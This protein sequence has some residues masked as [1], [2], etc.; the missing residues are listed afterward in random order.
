MSRQLITQL[1][2]DLQRD[3]GAVRA[4]CQQRNSIAFARGTRALQGFARKPGNDGP[5]APALLLGH[6]PRRGKNIVV[7]RECC[8]HAAH[9]NS[10]AGSCASAPPDMKMLAGPGAAGFA[11]VACVSFDRATW[12]VMLVGGDGAEDDCLVLALDHVSKLS[13]MVRHRTPGST[14]LPGSRGRTAK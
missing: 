13:R 14:R 3:R 7:N 2:D 6:C 10:H 4:G 12:R 5:D 11:Q 8:T 9:R 1:I